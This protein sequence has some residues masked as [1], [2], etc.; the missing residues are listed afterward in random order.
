MPITTIYTLSDPITGL[1]RY[2]GK[3][4]NPKQRIRNHL[5]KRENN[6]KGNWIESLRRQGLEPVVNFIDEVPTEEWSFWGS[7]GFRPS[8][9]GGSR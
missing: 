4:R 9:D 3:T 6:H 8:S 5:G 2:V 7:I 1:V